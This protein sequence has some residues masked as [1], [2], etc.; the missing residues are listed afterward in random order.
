MTEDFDSYCLRGEC[1]DVGLV[2]KANEDSCGNKITQ[3]GFVSVVCDGMGG[4]VGGATASRIAVETIFGVLDSQTFADP[5]EAIGVS[6]EAANRE[7]LKAA[8]AKPELTGMGSTCVMLLVRN[9]L[10]YLGHV[11]DSR[12]YLVRDRRITQ[13]TK[14]HSYVQMLVDAGRITPEEA[15]RHPRKNEITNALGLANMQPPTI[16]PNPIE[17]EAGDCFVL[18]SD[19]LSGMVSDKTIAAVA[20][21]HEVHIQQRAVTLVEKAKAGGGVDNISVELVEFATIPGRNKRSTPVTDPGVSQTAR[22]KLFGGKAAWIIIALLAVLVI[23]G[24]IFSVRSCSNNSTKDGLTQE[25]EQTEENGLGSED[26]IGDGTI[27]E[28]IS[29]QDLGKPK[30]TQNVGTIT[31]QSGVPFMKVISAPGNVTLEFTADGIAKQIALPSNDMLGRNAFSNPTKN[32][33]ITTEDKGEFTVTKIS[34]KVKKAKGVKLIILTSDAIYEYVFD[35]REQT[36]AQGGESGNGGALDAITGGASGGS[37]G[38]KGVSTQPNGKD[39]PAT[40]I[41]D[42]PQPEIQ[43]PEAPETP[44]SEDPQ[45]NNV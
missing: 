35:L 29:G 34:A 8:A 45:G 26:E 36:A 2:R 7:I 20:G 18:C 3:N 41:P 1:T 25:T 38:G 6:I 32:L 23:L 17:P 28:G 21:N 44:E 16:M 27:Q 12:I 22:E 31:V 30:R 15:E 13:L 43:A 4:H 42:A 14:D 11:G 33:I 10:V 19:G 37:K 39:V 5:R 24:V 40:V 9:G